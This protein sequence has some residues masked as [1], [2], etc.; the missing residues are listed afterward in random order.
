[1]GT[2]SS[3]GGASAAAT[4]AIQ[5]VVGQSAGAAAVGTINAST[6]GWTISTSGHLIP[7][8][9]SAQDLGT[10]A[11]PLRDLYLSGSSVSLDGAVVVGKSAGEVEIG[12]A[13]ADGKLT[14][15]SLNNVFILAG[16]D[17]GVSATNEISLSGS[18]VT[19]T[20]STLKCVSSG[21]DILRAS[22]GGLDIGGSHASLT[23][24]GSGQILPQTGSVGAPAYAFA[25]DLGTGMFSTGT[26]N[27]ALA[28]NG[29]LVLQGTT[30][31]TI[32]YGA[33]SQMIRLAEGSSVTFTASV[34]GVPA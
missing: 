2:P 11:N 29:G 13:S 20:G 32:L 8:G 34:V 28:A 18:I 12:G 14:I 22:V 19:I 1:M 21:V 10:N 33:G 7:I 26:T 4:H 17:I 6:R 5:M 27:V 16:S 30:T 25:G 9:V 23:L 31:T 3:D 15:S 24:S